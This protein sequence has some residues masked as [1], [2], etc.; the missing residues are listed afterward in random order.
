MVTEQIAAGDA[1][2][3]ATGTTIPP[4]DPE[5]AGALSHAHDALEGIPARHTTKVYVGTFTRRD[6]YQV[7][8]EVT[9]TGRK[10]T[11]R[12]LRHLEVH[13]PDGFAWGY[14]GSGPA[15][16]AVA[17]LAD[18]TG[19]SYLAVVKHQAFKS[20]VVAGLGHP[21]TEGGEVH[22]FRLEA[23]AVL[24]W[25]KGNVDDEDREEI[26][27]QRRHGSLKRMGVRRINGRVQG[28]PR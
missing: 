26:A 11:T 6:W 28:P 21:R 4:T 7:R 15:D 27:W 5:R 13:S 12:T 16:L 17:L 22:G 20:A 19:D 10:M 24:R 23:A 3:P 2:G 1:Y 25:V 14:G 8:V 18:A 9:R